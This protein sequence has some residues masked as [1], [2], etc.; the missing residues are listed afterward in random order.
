MRLTALAAVVLFV[1]ALASAEP[2]TFVTTPAGDSVAVIDLA[3]NT[4]AASLPVGGLPTGCAVGRAGRRV[5]VALAR[6]T[7]SPSSI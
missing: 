1:P 4:V 5:Y 7:R 3:A 6:R 2:F